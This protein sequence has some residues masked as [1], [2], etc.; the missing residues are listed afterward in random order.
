MRIAIYGSGGVGGYFGGRLAQA[1]QDVRFI[2]R[3][4]HLEAM[5]RNGLKVD[6]IAGDFKLSKIQ[7]TDS[8]R[9]VGIVDYIICGVKAWQV[10]AAAKAMK[11]M[12]DAN[13]LVIPL[14][15]GVEAPTQLAEILGI[16]QVLGGLCAIIA[17]LKA[18]GH[19]KHIGANPLIR[20][21]HIDRHADPRV[22]ALSE[23]FNRCHGVKSSIPE[24][25]RVAMWQKFMLITAWSGVG[26]ITRAPIGVLLKLSETRQMLIDALE[27]I[28]QLAL[29]HKISLPQDSVEK[30]IKTLESFPAN[31]TTSMQ[32][33][34]AEGSPSEL[35]VQ[36]DAVVRLAG[37]VGLPVPVNRFILHSLRPTELRARGAL[38]F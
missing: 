22:N 30:T 1:G 27:E 28:Y 3:G 12:V 21:G 29:A 36:N 19:I 17:F 33:D 9:A 14:Q 8:P 2:A 11:P 35:D 4:E 18:P 34:I 31:S 32:R 38:N 25:I 37:E 15:N 16:D 7:V 6:S 5:R 10:P 24:D 26:A 13:T 20:F 23:V